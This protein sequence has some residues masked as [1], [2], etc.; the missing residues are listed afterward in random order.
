M[1]RRIRLC[2][3]L[4]CNNQ[5]CLAELVVTGIVAQMPHRADSQYDREIRAQL[6]ELP[7]QHV[8]GFDDLGSSHPAPFEPVGRHSMAIR[9]W[10]PASS[11]KVYERRP[12][13]QNQYISTLKMQTGLG[14]S[15]VYS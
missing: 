2:Q 5:L 9:D 6:E 4:S 14:K 7:N 8:I 11:Q 1:H 13:C 3:S 10:L 15:L 12:E